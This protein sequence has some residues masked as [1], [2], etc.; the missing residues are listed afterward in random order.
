LTGIENERP[1]TKKIYTWPVDPKK[2]SF[3]PKEVYE[4]ELPFTESDL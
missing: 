4:Q 3:D 1:E 2:L